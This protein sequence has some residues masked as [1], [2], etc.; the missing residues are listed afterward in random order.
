MKHHHP[1]L[2]NTLTCTATLCA[3]ALASAHAATLTWDG[4]TDNTWA[5][6]TNWV[7]D[8]APVGG[9]TIVFGGAGGTLNN[10][11]GADTVF[12]LQFDAADGYDLDGNSIDLVNAGNVITQTAGSGTNI[13]SLDINDSIGDFR[14]TVNEG[15]L[16]IDGVITTSK[17]V[18]SGA[19]T[20]RLT[21]DGNTFSE[22]Y[23]LSGTLAFENNALGTGNIRL[24]WGSGT[25]GLEYVGSGVQSVANL[26]EIGG[27]NT[28][29]GGGIISNNSADSSTLTFTG[30]N[31]NA[32]D[33][34]DVTRDIEFNGASDIVVQGVI[35]DNSNPVTLTKTGSNTLTLEGA[36]TYTGNTTVSGGELVVS[37]TNAAVNSYQSATT[38]ANGATLSFSST[39]NVNNQQ[40]GR[41]I[42]LQDGSTLQNL[43]TNRFIVFNTQGGGT[44]VDTGASVTI[45]V[46][47]SSGNNGFYLDDGLKSTG[48]D[49]TGTVTINV[50]NA[51]AG[52]IL[53]NDNS[54]FAGTMIVNGIAS[55]A[56]GAGSGIGVS[57][58]TT[59]LQNADIQLNGTMELKRRSGGLSWAGTNILASTFQMGA[60]SGSGVMVGNHN[61]AGGT[62]SVTLGNTNNDGT[63]SGV[64]ADGENNVTSITKVGTGTQTFSGAN[65]HTGG[66][67]LSDGRLHLGA[68]GAAG[69]GTLTLSGGTLTGL[70]SSTAQTNDIVV[71][72]STSTAIFSDSTGE[73]RYSGNISG[74]GTLNFGGTGSGQGTGV[75][76]IYNL[77]NFTGTINHEA[78]SGTLFMEPGALTE[79]TTAK[80]STSGATNGTGI[81]FRGGWTIGEL[82][83][84][85]GRIWGWTNET[86]TINQSTNTTYSGN[87]SD[88]DPGRPFSINKA[89]SGT[90]TLDSANSHTGTTT[91]SGGTL[92]LA[93]GSSHSGTGA[94]TVNGGTLEIATGVDLSGH[95]MTI[96]GVISPGNSPGTAATGAQTWLDGGSYLWEINDSG[97][98]QGADSGWDWL[99]ITGALDLTS[100]TAGGFTID[101]DSLTLGNVAG[102]AAGF[103]SYIQLD[104]IADYSFT[105][106][107]ASGGISGFDES[108]F[109]LDYSGFSNAPGWDWAIVESGN[110]LVLEAYAVPEPS[111]TALLG[112]GGLALALRRKRS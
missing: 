37:G 25:G 102:N 60:L 7:G 43:S 16:I 57:G 26:V 99:D 86:L 8:V 87:I 23:I 47:S 97:G 61:T 63:F 65:T 33:T 31:F 84:T 90:L 103:D 98:T 83:G 4:D 54:T 34:A 112:L 12:R 44:T 59:G 35:S 2:K 88:N 27:N 73:N 28:H 96:A 108:L 24:G 66:T 52:V 101:I 106:A 13:I 70:G 48:A 110:N 77:D 111:S 11:I 92:S 41:S 36:N 76:R 82:S 9:D 38:V 10:D 71:T 109:T 1:L 18:S 22:S 55:T 91:V 50:T 75:V 94:Y 53:R 21:N 80:I 14:P 104:G 29:T 15:T 69:T 3:L 58:S 105:I 20:V 100:L 6:G 56:V 62:A 45:N 30:A 42:V 81:R 85:G 93:S 46:E 51:G 40:T 68:I 95:A 78:G 107:T 67:T 17:I 79:T 5:D 64:I 32:V 39:G 89:G 72:A 74:S 49:T 19:G